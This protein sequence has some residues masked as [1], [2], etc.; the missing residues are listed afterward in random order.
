MPVEYKDMTDQQL[1]FAALA[2]LMRGEHN[3]LW[4]QLRERSG[5][6]CYHEWQD[7]REFGE[8]YF[9]SCR[10]CGLQRDPKTLKQPDLR[11]QNAD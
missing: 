7:K 11:R 4:S 2:K 6:P 3:K 8:I 9:S 1:M 5:E 10:W